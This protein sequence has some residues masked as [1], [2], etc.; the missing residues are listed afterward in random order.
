M[1]GPH[2]LLPRNVSLVS[3]TIA[4][5]FRGRIIFLTSR[6]L[7]VRSCA[8]SARFPRAN[9]SPDRTFGVE[10][11]TIFRSIRYPPQTLRVQKVSM[12][13]MASRGMV[14][15]KSRIGKDADATP[16]RELA[17]SF[18]SSR[19]RD[20]KLMLWRSWTW[21]R[22]RPRSRCRSWRRRYTWCRRRRY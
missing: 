13:K 20:F 16:Q 17:N 5:K 8:D 7:R 15:R 12:A 14:P 18:A 6:I 22:S 11:E 21:V 2:S 1:F 4:T 9:A 3:R 10:A 19:N